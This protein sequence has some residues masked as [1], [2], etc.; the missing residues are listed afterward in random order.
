MK[1]FK[2]IIVALCCVGTCIPFLINTA[3]A[4]STFSSD[5]LKSACINYIKKNIKDDVE[6]AITQNIE[7]QK[8]SESNIKAKCSGDLSRLRRFSFINIEFYH[9]DKIVKRLTVPVKIRF[10]ADVA[11]CKKD[12]A[13]NTIIEADDFEVKRMD[14]SGYNSYDFPELKNLVGAKSRVYLSE[15]KIIGKAFIEE[16]QTVKKGDKVN[17]ISVSGPVCVKAEGT[18][19]QSG[20]I[21]QKIR[22]QREGLKG[23]S[24]PK[25]LDAEVSSE[26]IVVINN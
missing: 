21:G 7:T 3:S 11:V 1:N 4:Q 23:G 12:I 25:I 2:K 16:K 10:F 19:L 15:G 9:D 13:R 17:I 26:G 14:V 8:F 6:I 22:V 20:K 5:R 24:T 18:A